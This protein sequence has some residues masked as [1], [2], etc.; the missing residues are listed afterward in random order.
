VPETM[1][2]DIPYGTPISLDEA[3]KAIIRR[4]G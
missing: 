2:F 3:H 1:P 4:G